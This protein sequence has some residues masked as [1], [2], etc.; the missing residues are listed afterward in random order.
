M[1]TILGS[2]IVA[3]PY[4]MSQSGYALFGI[5]LVCCAVLSNSGI[6]LLLTLCDLTGEVKYESLGA[7]AFGKWGKRVVGL[8][9]M[10]QNISGITSYMLIVKEVGPSIVSHF[11]CGK[12]H[13]DVGIWTDTVFVVIV[14]TTVIIMP[15]ALARNIGFLSY[16]SGLAFAI[17]VFFV[18]TLVSGPYST[19]IAPKCVRGPVRIANAAEIHENH[20]EVYAFQFSTRIFFV[21][22][23]VLFAFVCHTTVIPVYKVR[24]AHMLY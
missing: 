13:C 5:I 2:G 15:L 16:F 3:L 6:Y 24:G 22:P 1:N 18:A 21:I 20:C 12:E 17:N 19:A 10:G 8:S 11:V 23:T 7:R 4:A 9:V 14:F